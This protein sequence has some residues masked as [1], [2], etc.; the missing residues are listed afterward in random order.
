MD[1]AKSGAEAGRVLSLLLPAAPFQLLPYSRL[2]S[3]LSALR[4]V[5]SEDC[6]EGT[7]SRCKG[8]GGRGVRRVWWG[9]G[10]DLPIPSSPT[11]QLLPQTRSHTHLEKKESGIQ[12][13][14]WR[15]VLN[16]CGEC[17]RTREEGGRVRNAPPTSGPG[18]LPVR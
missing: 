11:P 5:R 14:V 4:C 10:L 6:K 7:Q 3:H 13:R 18:S 1:G 8:L 12:V 2:R 16:L 9:W 15:E 17:E